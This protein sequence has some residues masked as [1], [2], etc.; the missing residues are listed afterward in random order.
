G[1]STVCSHLFLPRWRRPSPSEDWVGFPRL[2]H[3]LRLLAG[4]CFEVADISLCSGLQVCSPPRSSLPLCILPQGSRGFYVRAY[5]ASLPPHAPDMLTVRRQAID[6]TGTCT[7]LDSQPCRLLTW[8][9]GHYS[10]SPLLRTPP[11]PSRRSPISR[12][13]R[14]YGSLLRRFRGG[15]RRA[16]PVARCILV[17]VLSLPP[18][19]SVPPPQSIATFHAA[20]ALSAGAQPL[21]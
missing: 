7:L 3:E 19:Q 2:S 4:P 15:A 14:L 1:G 5:R 12:L 16:S 9:H 8:L 20:F 6:G 18:R 11:P 21:R 17:I 13:R 10:A